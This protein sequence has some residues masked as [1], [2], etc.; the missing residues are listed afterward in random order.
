MTI[1]GDTS[2]RPVCNLVT[3][4]H[5]SEDQI[6]GFLDSLAADRSPIRVVVVD[7]ASPDRSVDVARSRPGVTVLA[8]TTNGGYAAGINLGRRHLGSGLPLVVANPDVRFGPDAVA[9]LLATLDDPSVGMAVPRLV[10]GDGRPHRSLR[11]EP[12]IGR[13]LGEALFGDHLPGRPGWCAEIVRDPVSYE[14][15]G[16]VDWATG[17]VLAL[18]PEG[19]RT[20]GDW[21]ESFFLYSEEVDAAARLRDAGLRI[22]YEPSAVAVHV[23]GASGTSPALVALQAVNRVRYYRSRHGRVAAGAYRTVVA[24]HEA[25]R[26]RDPARR[27]AVRAVLGLP[28]RAPDQG[29][30]REP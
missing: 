10:D 17:A 21:D 29:R 30:S 1:V 28:T 7:N 3:V 13:E 14:H 24:L 25:S 11:R 23:G 19:D 22:C 16:D 2:V 27:A 8:S 6:G 20:I 4:T 15:S 9:T 18:S 5:R 12:S 26:S